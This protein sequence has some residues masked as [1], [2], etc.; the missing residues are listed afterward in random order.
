MITSRC[1]LLAALRRLGKVSYVLLGIISNI[2]ETLWISV[3]IFCKFRISYIFEWS[4]KV[5]QFYAAYFY[6]YS[7]N[8]WQ[9]TSKLPSVAIPCYKVRL[10]YNLVVNF[11]AWNFERMRTRFMDTVIYLFLL[12]LLQKTLSRAP[13]PAKNVARRLWADGYV[14]KN[15]HISKSIW[16]FE[17]LFEN[18]SPL[19]M[20]A[21]SCKV[22]NLYA[23]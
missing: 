21:S 3:D 20:S 16:V 6:C 11:A 23:L 5:L 4:Y 9:V 10:H 15:A 13:S 17:V 7:I 19:G 18:F 14:T 1:T 12:F 22:S 2:S 8:F